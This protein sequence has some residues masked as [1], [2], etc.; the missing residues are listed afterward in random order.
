MSD[1]KLT[2][3]ELRAQQTR[4]TQFL[5]YLPTLQLKKSMLQFEVMAA[6]MEISRLRDDLSL[7][8]RQAEAFAALLVEKVSIDLVQS[9]DVLH[10]K[11]AV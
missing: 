8:V 6:E 10:V 4:L 1:L 2:K 3:T 9:A 5:R 11:K 7:S